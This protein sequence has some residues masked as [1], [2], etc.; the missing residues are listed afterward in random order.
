M[1]YVNPVPDPASLSRL[2]SDGSIDPVRTNAAERRPEVRSAPASSRLKW[3]LHSLNDWLRGHPHDWPDEEGASRRILDFGCHDGEKLVRLY[4]RGWDVAGIDLNEHAIAAARVRFPDGKFWCGDLLTLRID[5]RFDCIVSD[6]VVE[7]LLDPVAY[8]A[9]LANL[10]KPGRELRIF[11]PN[12]AALSA[13]IFGRHS[14]VYWMPLHLN[15]FTKESLI[16]SLEKAGLTEVRCDTFTPIGSWT[17]TLRQALLRP[18]YNR[19]PPSGLDRLLQ[20]LAIAWYP[21][22]TL[23]QWVGLG[24]ELVA[25]GRRPV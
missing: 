13:R 23:A 15:L 25:T 4:R 8:L 20:R 5:D 19:H 12:G 9:A 7:H 21:F 10:L 22:E 11:V 1:R 18:G 17:W 3:A 6:N 16:R 14:A 2:Y 24:E